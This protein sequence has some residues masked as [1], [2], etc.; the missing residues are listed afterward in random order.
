MLK[1]IGELLKLP[2]AAL[3]YSMEA[4]AVA[5][6]EVRRISERGIDDLVGGAARALAESPGG[7]RRAGGE[8]ENASNATTEEATTLNDQD[9]GG[10]DLKYVTYSILF[11]KRDLEAT[12]ER[13]HQDVVNYSTDGG[14][15]GALKIA[16]FM[17]RVAAG[18]VRRP[19]VWA[20]NGY[21]EGFKAGVPWKIPAEDEKY[22]T[23]VF[24]VD[25]RLERQDAQYDKD[26]VKVL[27]EIRD[28]L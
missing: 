20:Q 19:T 15:Y 6:G 13:E 12:L 10:D 2:M 5:T 3:A 16:H 28:R 7:G 14:S 17:A 8:P 11:T 25:R 26:Q 27:K 9:L 22:I 18:E 24:S 4:L 23:F 1:L 21:P